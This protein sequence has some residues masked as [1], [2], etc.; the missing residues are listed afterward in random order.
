MAVFTP[1][2][3][4]DI[5][6]HLTQ[7]D[8]GALVSFD[9]IEAGVSNTNY[10]VETTKNRYVLTLFEPHRVRAEDIPA[11]VEYST[12]LEQNGVPCPKTIRTKSG[13]S[14]VTLK[15]RPSAFFSVLHGVCGSVGMLTPYLCA[16]GGETLAKMHRAAMHIKTKTP[17]H[18]GIT[19]W[20]KWVDGIGSSMNAIED[21]LFDTVRTEMDF[22]N[23]NWPK[24][25]PRGQIH[26]DYFA[27]NVF[28]ENSNV[29]GVIDFHFV[30]DDFFA[31]D[32]A[33]AINAWSFDSQNVFQPERMDSML[34]GYES[35]RPLTAGERERFPALLR[36][37]SLRFLLSRIEEKL[38]WK[39]GDFMVPHDPLVFE[40]R[41]QHFR[42]AMV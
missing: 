38:K 14:I 19:K 36:A 4:D 7:Y 12:V 29:T 21:G 8:L 27:D 32:L 37:A 3:T 40:K 30:C 23:Q 11:Y 5:L 6:T 2:D 20:N 10:F 25:L 15:N 31:Y 39:A 1:L 42:G 13:A 18:F 22:I 35:I 41:L 24:D 9:G 16:R 26:G 34:T 33:I 28:F 17:N